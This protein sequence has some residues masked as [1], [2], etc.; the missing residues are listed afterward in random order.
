[1]TEKERGATF[2]EKLNNLDRRIIFVLVFCLVSLPMILK[3]PSQVT[4]SP[5]VK[6]AYDYIE[7][8]PEHSI[9]MFSVDYDATSMPEIQPMALAMMRHA[10]SR[11]LKIILTGQ[12]AIGMPLGTQ[13]MEETAAVYGKKYGVDY[14]NLGYRPGYQAV[15]VAMGREFR[16]LF[17]NDYR[18]TPIDNYPMMKGVHNYGNL[19]CVVVLAHGGT[20]ENWIQYAQS[21]FGVKLIIGTTAVGAP[22]Y[23]SYLQAEQLVGL[24][25][26][27][28][29]AA[30]YETLVKAPG[31][32]LLAM[33][34][35]SWVHMAI[36]GLILLG[37]VTFFLV[38]RKA[39]KVEQK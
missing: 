22:D 19:G 2:L 11:N 5:E 39:K 30:E 6:K 16:D 26:G 37:N 8:L 33:A 23:Y 1:M 27:M 17:A 36:L 31:L 28:R 24:L 35:Q 3:L 15:I 12:I 10:F 34:P 25:G 13:A 9:V 38:K 29:G 32:G 20:V 21:R 4:I 18:G 7:A 14:I